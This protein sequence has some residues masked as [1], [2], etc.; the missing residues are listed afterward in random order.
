MSKDFCTHGTGLLKDPLQGSLDSVETNI[1]YT[2]DEL[3]TTMKLAS[4]VEDI[5]ARQISGKLNEAYSL[6][7]QLRS[8]RNAQCANGATHVG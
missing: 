5:V 4:P 8:A 6:V 7:L 2:L 3:Q 1:R